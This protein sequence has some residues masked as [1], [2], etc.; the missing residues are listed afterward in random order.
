MMFLF[1]VRL[2]V[3]LCTVDQLIRSVENVIDM[4]NAPDSKF[5]KRVSK[6]A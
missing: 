4:S 3:Y 6:G 2:S 5:G 1:D